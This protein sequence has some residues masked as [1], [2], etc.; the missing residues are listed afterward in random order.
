MTAKCRTMPAIR[1]MHPAKWR[2]HPAKCRPKYKYKVKFKYKTKI[3]INAI[4]PG[5]VPTPLTLGAFAAMG[6]DEEQVHQT[7]GAAN[8][9][10]LN[11]PDEVAGLA[12]FL[13]SEKADRLTGQII[14]MN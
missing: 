14:M 8:P 12:L 2:R 1:G 13:L 7:M 9:R 6:M 3:N 11:S 10:G 4:M 5:I